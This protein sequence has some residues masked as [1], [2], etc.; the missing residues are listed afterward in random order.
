MP[1]ARSWEWKAPML[2]G[3]ICKDYRFIIRNK[4]RHN[5]PRVHDVVAQLSLIIDATRIGAP[6]RKPQPVNKGNAC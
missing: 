4:G 5:T 1:A 2:H 3:V 6:H